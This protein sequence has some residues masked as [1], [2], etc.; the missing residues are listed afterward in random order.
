MNTVNTEKGTEKIARV[1]ALKFLKQNH[2]AVLATSFED[3]PQA[4][5]IYYAVDDDFNFIF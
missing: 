5:M 3:Q 4:S 2:I 1:D